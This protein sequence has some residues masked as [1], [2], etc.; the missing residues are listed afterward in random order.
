MEKKLSGNVLYLI[1]IF[2]NNYCNTEYVP[3]NKWLFQQKTLRPENFTF[4]VVLVFKLQG[5][6]DITY[7]NNKKKTIESYIC[8]K[9]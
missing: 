6:K 4:I 9:C 2:P 1:Y 5:R 7:N 3:T 8:A